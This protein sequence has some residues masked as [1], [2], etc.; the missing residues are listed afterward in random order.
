MPN[1]YPTMPRLMCGMQ[2][3]DT[4]EQLF[5]ELSEPTLRQL[6]PA[7]DKMSAAGQKLIRLLHTELTKGELGDDTFHQLVT[8]TVLT[9]RTFNRGAL[10]RNDR[11]LFS[12][13][14]IDEEWILEGEA[15]H[16]MDQY[17]AAVL[18]VMSSM[19]TEDDETSLGAPNR[20]L[21]RPREDDG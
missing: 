14:D 10:S 7:F 11:R 19:P 12:Q 20:Y 3:P 8:L 15:L 18:A 5:E 9:W 13:E 17:L 1:Q 6:F 21:I 16:R 4:P 2:I